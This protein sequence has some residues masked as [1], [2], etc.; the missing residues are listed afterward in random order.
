[1][2]AALVL[3]GILAAPVGT[4]ALLIGSGH[5]ART[6]GAWPMTRRFAF[7][8]VGT[9]V[10]AALAGVAMRLLGV[11]EHNS[12]AGAMLIPALFLPRAR[13]P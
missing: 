4:A 5:P 2:L 8:V 9:V 6:A 10:L 3:A 7:A 1:M 11:T 13:Q 12:I